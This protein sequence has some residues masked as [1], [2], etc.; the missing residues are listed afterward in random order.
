MW[1]CRWCHLFSLQVLTV[2]IPWVWQRVPTFFP[3]ARCPSQCT[4]PRTPPTQARPRGSWHWGWGEIFWHL[5]GSVDKTGIGGNLKVGV[6]EIT[7]M[8]GSEVISY[9]ILTLR[10][11]IFPRIGETT[12]LI[13]MVCEVFGELFSSST[14]DV[15]SLD[16]PSSRCSGVL[17]LTWIDEESDSV[18]LASLDSVPAESCDVIDGVESIPVCS[19]TLRHDCFVVE[20]SSFRLVSSDAVRKSDGATFN[21]T[22]RSWSL[23]SSFMRSGL[24]VGDLGDNKGSSRGQTSLAALISTTSACLLNSTGLGISLCSWRNRQFKNLFDLNT[25]IPYPQLP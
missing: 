12:G 14:V 5:N 10:L 22:G 9:K 23:M 8:E 2:W 4:S 15:S 3:S 19:I 20:S 24:W 11:E 7:D 17:S 18:W 21:E 16:C 25:Q 13:R 6:G 1:Q